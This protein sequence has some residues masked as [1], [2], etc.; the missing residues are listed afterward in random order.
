MKFVLE[1]SPAHRISTI[2]IMGTPA[3]GVVEMWIERNERWVLEYS[4]ERLTVMQVRTAAD[5]RLVPKN[6]VLCDNVVP[7]E[8][9][10]R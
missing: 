1:Q 9:S 6:W 5:S 8:F 7:N 3:H 2:A 10:R 4:D